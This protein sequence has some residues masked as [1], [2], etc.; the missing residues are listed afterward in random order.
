MEENEELAILMKG[1]RG[2]N[3]RDAQFAD[4]NI[5][6]RLVEVLYFLSWLKYLN[7][8]VSEY[9]VISRIFNISSRYRSLLY[10]V[11]NQVLQNDLYLICHLCISGYNCRISFFCFWNVECLCDFCMNYNSF[12]EFRVL[13]G[14]GNYVNWTG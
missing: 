14:S 2:Q 1:L 6:L 11:L 13:D 5:K 8:S 12:M 3:L 4:D 10:L 7:C 9:L